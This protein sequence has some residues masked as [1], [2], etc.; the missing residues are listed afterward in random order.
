MDTIQDFINFFLVFIP[1]AG[2]AKAISLKMA[3]SA[4]EEE[5][6][7]KKHIRNIF[8]FCILAETITGI[9]KLIASYF[10]GGVIH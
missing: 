9:I 6:S 5:N 1:A 8:C 10:G 2:V 7:H 4:S 3:D